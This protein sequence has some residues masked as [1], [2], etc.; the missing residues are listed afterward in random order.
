[1][2]QVKK[3]VW[4]IEPDGGSLFPGI[5]RAARPAI[6]DDLNEGILHRKLEAG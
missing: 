1:L 4:V 5:G 6:S 2:A 3:G